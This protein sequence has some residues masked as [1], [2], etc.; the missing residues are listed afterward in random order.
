MTSS[1]GRDK[2]NTGEGRP[3]GL[4]LSTRMLLV[5]CGVWLLY[6]GAVYAIY[7]RVIFPSFEDLEHQNARDNMSRVVQALDGEV[8]H[9]DRFLVDWSSWDDTVA[10]VESEDPAY[11]K[12]NLNEETFANANIDV[13]Y[14][15]NADGKV[16][17]GKCYD[18]DSEAFI[19]VPDFPK[20]VFPE[21]HELIFRRGEPGD[22]V[23]LSKAGII[24]TSRGLL[25]VASRPILTSKNEGP[26]RGTLFMGRFLDEGAIK[27]IKEKTRV[28]FSLTLLGG[29]G[30]TPEMRSIA[31]GMVPASPFPVRRRGENR[32]A[33]YAVYPD[34][35]HRPLILIAADMP[36]SILIKGRQT[37]A[38]AMLFSLAAVALIIVVL[39]ILVNR[40]V[41]R[42]ISGL[43]KHILDATASG[44]KPGRMETGRSDEIGALIRRYNALLD[45]IDRQKAE[46]ERSAIR[47]G[48]T[49][50]YNHRYITNRLAQEVARCVR[51]KD[52]L[53]IIFLDL[54]HFKRIN[55][56]FGHATGDEVLRAVAVAIRGSLRASDLVGRYG[57][58][59]FLAILPNQRSEGAMVAAERVRRAVESLSFSDESLRVT[60]S[61]GIATLDP[62][63]RPEDLIARSDER[64]Y[65]AKEEGRNRIVS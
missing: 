63:G 9:L 26:V 3:R 60:I 29:K 61:G 12:S 35:R 27:N 58:E 39:A 11:V 56:T 57:G 21:G 42:P 62:G 5:I 19:D 55:D 38:Y 44:P 53:A 6:G 47:D 52:D 24:K 4:S 28:A 37:V 17:Y 31:E 18:A 1:K 2:V 36:A 59:E 10:F 30:M 13:I 7:Q 25:V 49:G 15:L 65:R 22:P 32:I 33:V 23:L 43:T 54:D 46:L 16:M 8:K 14:I 20:D 64:L 45:E 34:L 51:Y 50:L 41:L 40:I 48:L